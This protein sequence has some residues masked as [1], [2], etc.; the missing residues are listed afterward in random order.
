MSITAGER[1]KEKT[2]RL[3][4]LKPGDIFRLPNIDFN[5]AIAGDE[6][7]N[8]YNV[9]GPTEKGLIPVF[10]TGQPDKKRKLPEE[11]DVIQHEWNLE[12]F[13]NT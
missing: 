1:K 2:V 8:F 9:E 11:T 5:T 7:V 12:I 3:G 13:P 4:N 10:T 6:G